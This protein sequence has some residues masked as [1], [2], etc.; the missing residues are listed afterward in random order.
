MV[1]IVIN[2]TKLKNMF[3]ILMPPKPKQFV[4][5]E[6]IEGSLCTWESL[7]C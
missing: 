5:K 7:L 3:L 6:I 1:A 4:V 2:F